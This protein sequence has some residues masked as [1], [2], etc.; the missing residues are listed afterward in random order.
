MPPPASAPSCA[1]E[2]G[3]G[4]VY[5]RKKE[6]AEHLARSLPRAMPAGCALRVAHYHAG[7]QGA[8]RTQVGGWAGGRVDTAC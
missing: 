5:V 8:Q 3:C 4:I 1:G 7:V 6:E 2:K